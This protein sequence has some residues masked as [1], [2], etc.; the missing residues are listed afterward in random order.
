MRQDGCDFSERSTTPGDSNG[1]A[2]RA[3]E[4]AESDA[5]RPDQVQVE[6]R[7][8]AAECWR[9]GGAFVRGDRLRRELVAEEAGEL[10][11]PRTRIA[12]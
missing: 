2:Q 12:L 9:R 11:A 10:L 7:V 6:K 4:S 8:E 1:G 3:L 5:R